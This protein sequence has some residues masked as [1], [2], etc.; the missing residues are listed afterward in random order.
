MRAITYS[1]TLY[2]VINC[3]GGWDLETPTLSLPNGFVRDTSNFEVSQVKGGGYRRVDGYER[4]NGEPAPS[5]A[6]F[7]I[8]QI[9]DQQITPG[10]WPAEDVFSTSGLAA[11]L[12]YVAPNFFVVTAATGAVNTGDNIYDA[13]AN[14]YGV[15]VDQTLVPTSEEIAIYTAAAADYYRTLVN[16]VPGSGPVRGV[17]V[18]PISNVD[19]VFAW[20]DNAGA[21]ACDIFKATASG[22]SAVT[23]FNEVSFTVGGTAPPAEGDTLTQGGVTAVI[24][25]VVHET[26]SWTGTSATGRLIIANPSGGNFAAG[27][28]TAPGTTLTLSGAQTAITLTAGGRYMFEVHNFFGTASKRRLYG[29][30][31]VQKAFEFDGTVYVPINHNDASR[32]PSQIAVFKE[33]L[34]LGV[35][36]SVLHSGPG[37]PYK[38]NAAAGGSEI[39]LGDTVTNLIRQPGDAQTGSLNITTRSNALVLYGTSTLNWNL[40]GLNVGVMGLAYTGS[41]LNQTYWLDDNGITNLVASQNFGNFDSAMLT[42]RIT[43]FIQSKR[44]FVVGSAVHREKSQYRLYFS[45]G[46]ALYCTIVNGKLFGLMPQQLEDAFYCLW[47]GPSNDGKLYAGGATSGYVYQL[48][49]GTSFD[50]DVIDAYLVFNWN[51]IKS[52]RI[53][54]RYRRASME[55]EGGVYANIQ[56]GYN[57]SYARSGVPQDTGRTYSVESSG[58]PFWDSFTWDEFFWDGSANTVLETE[59]RG[60]GENVQI[61]LRSG[62]NYI[63]SYTVNSIILHHTPRRGLR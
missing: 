40:V 45:D 55:M 37:E 62:T 24:K 12:I 42:N 38:I 47:D 17:A 35:E 48:D 44:G 52:P 11:T 43:S 33:H 32:F 5:D 28:A 18:L 3:Q 36:S 13:A 21:T 34:F 14:H 30:S 6:T 61:V 57:L 7:S 4:F 23:L 20:R 59:M 10:P 51:P 25:R 15:V 50:G 19:T 56:F 27:A 41:R 26:G 2:D 22:W 63:P 16:A 60:S 31:G 54:K 58:I 29:C 8:I 1:P 49:V 46:S 53:L 39:A 9:A